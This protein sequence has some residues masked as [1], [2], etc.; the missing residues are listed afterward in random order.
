M[1][2]FE[3]EREFCQYI[4]VTISVA[5]FLSK[6]LVFTAHIWRGCEAPFTTCTVPPTLLQI[7]IPIFQIYLKR[8]PAR[9][10][11]TK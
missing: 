9:F 7:L 4:N 1:I 11:S 5:I 8:L 10:L 3:R 6:Q 2:D